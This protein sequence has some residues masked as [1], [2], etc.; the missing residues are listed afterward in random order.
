MNK[1]GG[2]KEVMTKEGLTV[3]LRQRQL[4]DFIPVLVD[5]LEFRDVLDVKELSEISLLFM[6]FKLGQVKR[7]LRWLREES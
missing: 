6:G 2:K 7:L 4:E 3:W 5:R 1:P